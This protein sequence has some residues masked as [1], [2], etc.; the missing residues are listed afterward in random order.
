MVRKDFLE[1]AASDQSL[2]RQRG[3]GGAEE[4]RKYEEQKTVLGRQSSGQG[5]SV[6][7]PGIHVS[8]LW[9]SGIP[10]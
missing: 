3:F 1:E 7:G 9:F 6:G 2:E 8:Y 10:V 5:W 4:E